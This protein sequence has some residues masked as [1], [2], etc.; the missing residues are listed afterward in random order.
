LSPDEARL[1]D[2]DPEIP[3]ELNDRA[4]DCWRVLL[5]IADA[6]GA[7][8]GE[9]A[10]KAAIALGQDN[11]EAAWPKQLLALADIRDYVL[12]RPGRK[13]FTTSELADA[14]ALL[15]DRP[16]PEYRG[17]D[18]IT[19]FQLARLLGELKLKTAST[20]TRKEGRR[21]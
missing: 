11:T 10:R 12:A 2:A 4:A 9:E 14:L 6:A 19:K 5:T 17:R 8:V 15:E 3:E 16:W 13:D 7:A 20:G 1:V 18:A 21:G